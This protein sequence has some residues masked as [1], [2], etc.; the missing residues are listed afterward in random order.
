M[1]RA[2]PGHIKVRCVQCAEVFLSTS[3][4]RRYCKDCRVEAYPQCTRETAESIVALLMLP[5]GV[6]DVL[7]IRRS[8]KRDYGHVNEAWAR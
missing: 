7:T 1:K 6:S 8:G 3:N 2:K 5:H 4:S